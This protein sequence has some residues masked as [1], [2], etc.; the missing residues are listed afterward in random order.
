MHAALIVQRLISSTMILSGVMIVCL[1]CMNVFFRYFLQ[2]DIYGME[3]IITLIAF[4]MY[5]LSGT[6]ATLMDKQL[7][8][9]VIPMMIRNKS[10]LATVDILASFL[11]MLICGIYSWWGIKF[12]NWSL[13]EA[14]TSSQLQIP[15]W[16]GQAS[17]TFGLLSMQA[18]YMLSFAE[19]LR[20]YSAKRNVE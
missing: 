7:T 19:K 11:T 10:A 1:I 17:V 13:A 8:A 3:E 15:R 20:S 4:W 18:F 2:Q 16:V 5:F 6:Y 9:Q 12:F 14:G